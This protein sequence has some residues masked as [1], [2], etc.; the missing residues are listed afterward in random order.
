MSIADGTLPGALNAQF[1]LDGSGSAQQTTTLLGVAVGPLAHLQGYVV[2]P[3]GSPLP[4]VLTAA[5]YLTVVP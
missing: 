1:V 5:F 2:Q 4:L 3:A